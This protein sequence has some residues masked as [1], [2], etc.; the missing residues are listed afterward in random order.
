MGARK[1]QEKKSRKRIRTPPHIMEILK[2]HNVTGGAYYARRHR[3]MSHNEALGVRPC[4]TRTMT[5]G[6]QGGVNKDLMAGWGKAL[7]TLK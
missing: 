3:G 7:R 1:D 6:D 5:H 4:G 2:E